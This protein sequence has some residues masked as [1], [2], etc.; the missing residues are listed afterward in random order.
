[1]DINFTSHT[2][3]GSILRSEGGF[4]AGSWLVF[5][6]IC[7]L[8]VRS[9]ADIG[10]KCTLRGQSGGFRQFFSGALH[11]RFQGLGRVFC[12]QSKVLPPDRKILGL[13]A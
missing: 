13:L 9:S 7:G 8:A 1:M 4:G 11:S 6:C 2:S 3:S 5:L 12:W 10:L